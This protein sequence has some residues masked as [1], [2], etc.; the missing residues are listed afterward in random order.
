KRMADMNT[1][2]ISRIMMANINPVEQ[3][4]I[5]TVLAQS[6]ELDAIQESSHT[7][8]ILSEVQ[9]Q[10][11]DLIIVDSEWRNGHKAEI[12]RMLKELKSMKSSPPVV[13]IGSF[14][15][16]Q[17]V[18]EAY[19]EG[20]GSFVDKSCPNEEFLFAIDKVLGGRKYVC[21]VLDEY[22]AG[23][24]LNRDTKDA[25]RP[26]H[27]SLSGREYQVMLYLVQGLT[28][29]EIAQKLNINRKTVHTYKS[30]VY[31]KMQ[32]ENLK[33][34][35]MYAMRHGIANPCMMPDDYDN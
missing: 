35:M 25:M 26:L 8:D 21:P 32:V 3:I 12:L 7:Q 19:K 11:F 1:R 29:T 34:L 10:R 22:L 33:E 27:E 13:V 15:D 16:R 18:F 14:D 20:I 9:H 6:F 5:K 23:Q 4:G 30:R 2:S 24:I 31:E 17:Y 28:Q